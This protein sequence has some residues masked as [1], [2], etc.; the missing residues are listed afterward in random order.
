MIAAGYFFK[1]YI[2]NWE[3]NDTT[4]SWLIFMK[5]SHS[6]RVIYIFIL[7]AKCWSEV[8]DTLHWVAFLQHYVIMFFLHF[9]GPAFVVT[10]TLVVFLLVFLLMFSSCHIFILS[11]FIFFLLIFQG[12]LPKSHWLYSLSYS[13]FVY[14]LM[15]PEN[16]EPLMD[17][18]LYSYFMS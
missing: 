2:Y 8:K 17:S 1:A 11:E 4:L 12:F 14:L 9:P 3:G 7:E 6:E 5:S 10:F 16:W 13:C 15:S 18:L